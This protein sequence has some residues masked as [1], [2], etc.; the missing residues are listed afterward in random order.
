MSD[1]ECARVSL[2]KPPSIFSDDFDTH[3][4]SMMASKPN[5]PIVEGTKLDRRAAR[6]AIE[7]VRNETAVGFAEGAIHASTPVGASTVTTASHLGATLKS[8]RDV[9]TSAA[10]AVPDRWHGRGRDRQG[11]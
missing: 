7:L 4:A 9:V 8:A 1:D 3:V 2:P 10:T 6:K 11:P 5:A